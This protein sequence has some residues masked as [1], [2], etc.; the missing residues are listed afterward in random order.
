MLIKQ[1]H[2]SARQKIIIRYINTHGGICIQE[3]E[4][5]CLGVTRR[6]LQREIK[7]LIDKG[8]IQ[9]RGTANDMRYVMIIEQ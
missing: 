2:L 7:D 9:S 5:I 4:K 3:C 8:L 6:T 1:H